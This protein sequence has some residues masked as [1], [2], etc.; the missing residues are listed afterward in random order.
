MNGKRARRLLFA[1]FAISLLVHALV[2]LYVR[3]PFAAPKD[4][5][6]IVR[7][8]HARTLRVTRLPTP[9]PHTPPPVTPSPAPSAAPTSRV[10]AP[11]SHAIGTHGRRAAGGGEPSVSPMPP[12]PT[13]APSPTPNCMETDT[14]VTLL[15]KPE[16][17]DIAAVA[18][19]D[20]TSGITRV[21]V[22]VDHNGVVE[23]AAVTQSSGNTSLDLVA[24]SV[25][26]G[27]HYAPATH[28]CKPIAAHY[29]FRV[30]WQPW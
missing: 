11:P 24:T 22:L 16:A 15:S 19:A 3:W 14:P 9:P 20:A 30:K 5:I 28:A 26:R 25:A 7:I 21:D 27:A 18:R 6:Q 23:Q 2:A 12:S 29:T 1:A 4:E 13:V 8:E 17:P 10:K